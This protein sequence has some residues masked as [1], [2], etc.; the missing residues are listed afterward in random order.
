MK[1]LSVIVPVYNVEKYLAQCVES[2]LNQS[3]KEIEVILVDDGSTD[4]SGSMCDRFAQDDPR[5]KVIHQTNGGLMAARRSGLLASKCEYVTFVD[6]DDF[7]APQSYVLAEDAMNREVDVI[8]FGYT[9]YYSEWYQITEYCDF[10][11]GVYDRRDIDQIIGPTMIWDI[12]KERPG[13]NPSLCNKVIKRDVLSSAY[14]I[15]GD[16]NL[17]FG[18]DVAVTFP[19]LKEIKSLEIK[20]YS[21]YYYRQRD[22]SAVAPYFK[23]EMYL[24]K[25]YGLYQHL[26]GVFQGNYESIKQI[27]Y[28]YV[29]YV[30]RCKWKYEGRG[31]NINCQF[32]F[33]KVTKGERII[34]Y[35]AGTVGQA[36]M[37]QLQEMGYS[38]PALWID[39]NYQNCGL[40]DVSPVEAIQTVPYD[41]VVIAIKNGR[42]CDAVEEDLIRLGAKQEQLVR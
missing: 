8:A 19:L 31:S 18:E 29:Y 40:S 39:R 15:L 4:A 37:K 2:I 22:R 33:D 14:Q 11:E 24:D 26:C 34:L 12:L 17:Y 32:P 16:K 23:D 35:G 3:M 20:A 41:K 5:I 42:I 10:T 30:G 9:E 21:Y 1:R 36:Y 7:I 6:S 28:F 38:K 25:L 13:M 27:E